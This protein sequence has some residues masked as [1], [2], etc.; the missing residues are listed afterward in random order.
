MGGKSSKKAM[1][2][3]SK[4]YSVERA[5]GRGAYGTVHVIIETGESEK[6]L[7][8][9]FALKILEKGKLMEKGE[10]CVHFA[11]VERKLLTR[12]QHP[13]LVNLHCAFQDRTNCYLILDFMSGGD[14]G[15]HLDYL[16]KKN[17]SFDHDT[18]KFYMASMLKTLAYLHKERVIHRYVA[19]AFSLLSFYRVCEGVSVCA[20]CGCVYVCVFFVCFLSCSF[21]HIYLHIFIL[22][23][24]REFLC[25]CVC[26]CVLVCSLSLELLNS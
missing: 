6:N 2:V 15:Y 11:I 23:S 10:R 18:I 17:Q 7:D 19:L 16:A 3:G 9:M 26:F 21:S 13:G 4:T 12:L 22:L 24:S 20:R 1:Q 8:K 5:M 14:L 25:V